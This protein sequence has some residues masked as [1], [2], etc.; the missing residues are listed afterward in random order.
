[1]SNIKGRSMSDNVQQKV[2]VINASSGLSEVT[3]RFL[4]A[5]G[6]SVVLRRR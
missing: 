6:A 4:S 5:Q 2:V 1:M 3:A